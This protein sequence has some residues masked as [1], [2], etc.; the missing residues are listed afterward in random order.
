MGEPMC[1][2]L[3]RRSGLS[4]LAYDLRPEPLERLAAAGVKAASLAEIASDCGVILLSLPDGKAV[5]AV[6]GQLEPHLRE[7]QCVVDTSTS[8]VEL[9]RQIGARLEA[10]G[11]L[12]KFA[13]DQLEAQGPIEKHLLRMGPRNTRLIQAK[14]RE[15]LSALNG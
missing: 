3:V 10:K 6:I 7:G 8:P 11:A 4:V 13:Y 5:D 12:Y 1:S 14:A 2:H 9:T 15:I